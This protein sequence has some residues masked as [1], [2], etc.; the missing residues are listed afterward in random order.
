MKVGKNTPNKLRHGQAL[1]L[2]YAI[3]VLLNVSKGGSGLVCQIL[4]PDQLTA[5]NSVNTTALGCTYATRIILPFVLELALKGL[6]AKYNKDWAPT[7]HNLS[8]LYN[9]L[10]ENLRNE[11]NLDFENIKS[12][13]IPDEIR[14]LS[15]IIYNHNL[16][17]ENWRYL[18]KA[19]DLMTDDIYILQYIICSVL[20]VYNR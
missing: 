19:E 6:I 8:C 12:S 10:S 15:E 11:L 4:T 5:N 1:A 13:C 18:D 14:S 20:N 7:T 17:F 2:Q 9:T 16:D 3:Q